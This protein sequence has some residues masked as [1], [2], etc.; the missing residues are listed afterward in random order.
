[1]KCFQLS[2][3]LAAAVLVISSSR[4]FSA[5]DA[6]KESEKK[7][8]K[9]DATY[10]EIAEDPE[11]F[12]K[13][14]PKRC[15]KA[16]YNG[17]ITK[18]PPPYEKIL[19]KSICLLKI[20]NI[21]KEC[22]LL[23]S[24]R[25]EKLMKDIA[26]LEQEQLITIYATIQ[27]KIEKEDPKPG[28]IRTP[29]VIGKHYYLIVDGVDINTSS[30]DSVTRSENRASA[31]PADFGSVKYRLV[32]IQ[33]KNFI[34]KNV[35]FKIRFKDISNTIP[36]QIVKY[37]EISND[38]FFVLLPMDTFFLPM[39]VKRDN[40][41]CV[42]TIVDAEQGSLLNLCGTVRTIGDPAE[43]SNK[44]MYYI[45]LTSANTAAPSAKPQAPAV[46][47]ITE[48][49]QPSPPAP[50]PVPQPQP[51][52]TAPAQTPA[53]AVIPEKNIT[54]AAPTAAP[55]STTVQDEAE[56][57]KTELKQETQKTENEDKTP[58]TTKPPQK[59]ERKYIPST[60]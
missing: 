43:K 57:T 41:N 60:D 55:P 14:E 18:L 35:S 20:E 30:K 40:E 33:P 13:R 39:L 11:K 36:A 38:E 25:N 47:S 8:Y 6:L 17:Y 45:I 31:E 52:I 48:N 15:M 49:K 2:F 5:D 24:S 7:S 28:K 56:N 59:K 50:A 37:A 16:I 12:I 58:A 51:V 44:P 19:Q 23:F 9:T 4:L 3:F 1:M 53:P 54:P 10:A 27:Q 42:P 29:K 46:P 26:A 22:P 34:D 21:Q 32:D